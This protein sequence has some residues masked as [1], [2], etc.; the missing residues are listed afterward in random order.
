MKNK[1]KAVISVA[2]LNLTSLF[3]SPLW[4]F[5]QL[6]TPIGIT[7]ILYFLGGEKALLYGLIG[8]IVATVVHTSLSVARLVVILKLIGFQDIFVASPVTPLEYMLGLSLSRFIGALP[9]TFIFIALMF[10]KLPLTFQSFALVMLL[11]LLT[12]IQFSLIAFSVSL[13]IKNLVHVDAVTMILSTALILLPPVYYPLAKLPPLFQKIALLIPT[14]Y[15]AE[16][17][18]NALLNGSDYLTYLVGILIYCGI[19]IALISKK[20]SWGV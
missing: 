20:L 5:A 12:W 6:L 2:Y 3:R 19:S 8:A 17:L 18:R 7:L 4:I 1:F 9:A 16:I 14:T 10:Y 11:I 15:T 13:Y